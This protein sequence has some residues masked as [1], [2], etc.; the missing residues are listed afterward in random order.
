[1]KSE[2]TASLIIAGTGGCWTLY[3]YLADKR[4]FLREK[5]AEYFQRVLAAEE[6][7]HEAYFDGRP[8]IDSKKKHAG[9]YLS[10][11]GWHREENWKKSERYLVAAQDMNWCLAGINLFSSEKIIIKCG[12]LENISHM[13][14]S[15]Y[16]ETNQDRA[17][18]MNE[19]LNLMRKDLNIRATKV[20]GSWA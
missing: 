8:P 3:T 4:H 13:I 2:I 5:K 14:G 15:D 6:E 16:N 10:E 7:L 12:D 19:L 1:L 11:V 18:L 20:T 17:A 9:W